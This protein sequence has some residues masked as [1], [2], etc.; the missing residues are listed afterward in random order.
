MGGTCSASTVDTQ[1]H[2]LHEL[3]DIDISKMVVRSHR[4]HFPHR[5]LGDDNVITP[6]QASSSEAT[7]SHGKSV[8]DLGTDESECLV[9]LERACNVP[10][11][12]TIRDL[13]C[14][15]VASK[16]HGEPFM[17][18]WAEDAAGKI[19]GKVAE[20]PAKHANNAPS[21]YAAR[22]L[23]F[24]TMQD[25]VARLR[26]ELWDGSV[27]I[28][29]I[30][31]PFG[32]LPG[33]SVINEELELMPPSQQLAGKKCVVSFQVIDSR[34]ALAPRTIFF[35]RHGESSW[36][37]AQSKLDLYEMGRQ[38]DHPLSPAGREQ[39]EALNALIEKD[40][41]THERNARILRPDVVY[42]SPLTRAIQTAVIGLKKVLAEPGLGELVLMANAREKQN[43]GGFD[44]KPMKIGSDVVRR[45]LDELVLLYK[46]EDSIKG[47]VQA[48]KKLKFDA[49]EVQDVWW[50][51]VSAESDGQVKARMEEF[52]AQLK[53][54]PHRTIV[55]VGHSHFFRAIF[56][57]FLSDDFK[58]KQES[59]A[60]QLSTMK[61]SNCGVARLDLDPSITTGGPITD[62][63]L[64][65]GTKLDSDGGVCKC[66]G[67][68][69][70]MDGPEHE[71]KT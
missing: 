57:Q 23:G 70:R 34:E 25:G 38:S 33:H 28:G 7:P 52:M 43:F 2:E 54:S 68:Q 58:S 48:F 65:L 49:Q 3:A 50:N 64:V 40:A 5:K 31:K 46:N 47:V 9:F 37:K 60:R 45:T 17:K 18:A 36:N 67:P 22:S 8:R 16:A 20:W 29:S 12:D 63:E 39:A 41:K 55:V 26:L 44:S 61:L 27:Q 71:L 66:S 24:P 35:V 15:A 53:Y 4:R 10:Y 32:K 62:V 11:S 14:H 19:V 42:V 13:T 59:F 1:L 51:D 21:W 30:S 6:S 69:P 56:K